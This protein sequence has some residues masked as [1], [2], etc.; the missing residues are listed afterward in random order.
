MPVVVRAAE[1]VE[2]HGRRYPA[3][4]ARD[5]AARALRAPTLRR[6]RLLVR[7][8]ATAGPGDVADQVAWLTGAPAGRVLGLLDGPDPADDAALVLLAAD[9]DALERRVRSRGT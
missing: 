4:G 9:L 3:A 8:D 5:R 6:L 2:R 7:L 1:T